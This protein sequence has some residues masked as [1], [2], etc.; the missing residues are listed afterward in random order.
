MARLATR[1]AKPAGSFHLTRDNVHDFL[2]DVDVDQLHGFGYA[3]RGK[4]EAA[5]GT[6]NLV[7]LGQVKK[8]L[9][10]RT[11]GKKTGEIIWNASRGIDNS[12]LQ[13]DKPR[14]SV[15]CDINVR[16]VV[17][18]IFVDQISLFISLVYGLRTRNRRRSLYSRW[19][20]RCPRVSMQYLCADSTLP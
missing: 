10:V 2:V 16:I 18:F 5:Y 11:F 19:Q 3:L 14:Q 8:E 12:E 7:K 15:S 6:T 4:A 1:H 20:K 9:L 17:L 13:S